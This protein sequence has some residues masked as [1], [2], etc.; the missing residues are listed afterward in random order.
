MNLCF[1]SFKYFL[2]LIGFSI[3]THGAALESDLEIK[4]AKFEIRSSPMAVLA[5]WS[6]IDIAFMPDPNFSFGISFIEYANQSGSAG[7]L[8]PAQVGS[9][10]GLNLVYAEPLNLNSAYISF[11]GYIENFKSYPDLFS[12]FYD[13]SGTRA[14]AIIGRRWV[15]GHFITMLGIGLENKEHTFTIKPTSGNES[16]QAAKSTYFTA[17]FKIGW[18]F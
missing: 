9:A 1:N 2:I 17:E 8:Y 5:G 12:G 3:C 16:N 14:N 15:L 13:Y 11:H 7:D 18:I 10:Y 4:K 6:N